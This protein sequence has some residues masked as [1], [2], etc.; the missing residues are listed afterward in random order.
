MRP[1]LRKIRPYCIGIVVGLILA[2]GIA[3][4]QMEFDLSRILPFEANRLWLMKQ[5][6]SLLE[7]YHVD[8]DEAREEDKLFYGAV[9]GM[10]SAW[11][12]PYSRF[13]DPE[14]IKEE[15]IEMQG[16]YGGLGI[17]IGQRDGRTLVISPIEG[18]PADRAGLKPQ[19]EIVK[20]ND[21]VVVGW[22]INDVVKLLRGDPGTKV[23]IWVRREGENQLLDF[24]L[25]REIIQIKSVRY[26][27]IDDL[28]YVRIA[29]FTQRTTQEM[30]EALSELLPVQGMV[31]DLRN[32]PGGLLNAAVEV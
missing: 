25:V 2:G 19:D 10:V 15:E 9:K 27:K 14:E 12:D 5:T 24:E 21:E 16:E 11:G 1:F 28:G 4:A 8:G 30:E 22:Q 31:L 23:T 20:V 3:A 18:T 6:R 26:E 32:D 13:A 17:Y 29:Q 7:T